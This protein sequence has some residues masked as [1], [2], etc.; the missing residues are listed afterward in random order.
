[1]VDYNTVGY[2]MVDYNTVGY[3]MLDYNAGLYHGRL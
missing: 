2:I 1:M 3:I